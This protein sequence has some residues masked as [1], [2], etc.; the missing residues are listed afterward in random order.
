MSA[1]IL[2][3]KYTNMQSWEDTPEPV[4]FSQ[5]SI[6]VLI[7]RPEVGKT[8][9]FKPFIEAIFPGEFVDDGINWII[10]AGEDCCKTEYWLDTGSYVMFTFFHTTANFTWQK[11]GEEPV[12]YYQRNMPEELIKEFGFIVDYKTK[13]IINL[14]FKDTSYPFV[15][16]SGDFNSALLS[17]V[18]KNKETEKAIFNL[19]NWQVELQKELIPA[20]HKLN[21][22]LA[23][24]AQYTY[25]DVE[26]LEEI[27]REIEKFQNCYDTLEDL[28]NK[29]DNLQANLSR[30]SAIRNELYDITEVIDTRNIYV[31]LT[32][33][34]KQFEELR[35]SL[36]I[37]SRSQEQYIN[38]D[39]IIRY[40]DCY[41]VLSELEEKLNE[42]SEDTKY[43]N[44]LQEKIQIQSEIIPIVQ[45]I[46]EI[47]EVMKEVTQRY[48]EFRVELYKYLSTK[49]KLKEQ[50]QVVSDVLQHKEVASILKE[51]IPVVAELESELAKQI[52]IESTLTKN[53][54]R[55]AELKDIIKVCP[56]CGQELKDSW[57]D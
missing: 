28:G 32:S 18:V 33:I 24:D 3:F 30:M 31:E 47:T 54:N 21:Y 20:K 34:K 5:E 52:S 22:Y 56:M 46:K 41:E 29:M 42:Y 57:V 9:V 37:V 40:R 48:S 53:K 14:Y 43:L 16:T 50:N 26:K 35:N 25:S 45:S 38:I 12:V 23:K 19:K 10:R 27:L 2:K 1:K 44:S 49:K 51:V 15:C 11:P 8:A 39:E 36:Y 6:N 4:E 17:P 13:R 55:L 7:A